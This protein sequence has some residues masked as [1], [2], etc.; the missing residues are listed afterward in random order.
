MRISFIDI[1]K[2]LSY[3][4]LNCANTKN[5]YINYKIKYTEETKC[6]YYKY[7]KRA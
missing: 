2:T 4:K 7:C 3:E 5:N 1:N 6:H